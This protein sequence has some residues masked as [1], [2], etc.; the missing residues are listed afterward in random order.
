M[1]PDSLGAF[2][3]FLGLVAPGLTLN[4][5]LERR[6]PRQNGTAFREA[7]TIALASLVFTLIAVGLLALLRAARPSYVPDVSKWIS[8]GSSY[9]AAHWGIIS[10]SILLEVIIACGLAALCGWFVTRNSTASISG[11]GAWYQILR[12]DRPPGTRPWI[13]LRLDDETEFWGYLRHYTPD[14]SAD[15]REIVLGGTTLAWRPKGQGTRSAIGDKW[16]SVCINAERIQYMRVIYMS[17]AGDMLFS[18]KPE[19]APD[20]RPRA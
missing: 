6:R 15:V 18:R 8:Q 12:S 17:L 3:A 4:L 14:D 20:G 7:S 19:D 16:D 5:M 13:H 11:V 10:A 9:A 1:I 2:L